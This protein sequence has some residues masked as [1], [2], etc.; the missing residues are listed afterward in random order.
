MDQALNLRPAADVDSTADREPTTPGSRIVGALRSLGL[1][2]L[3]ILGVTGVTLL[4]CLAY[5]VMR[6]VEPPYTLLYGGLELDDSAQ[7][8]SRLEAMRVPFRL[9]G[10]GS[11]ILVPGT[12]RCACA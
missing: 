7:I 1:T 9:Q 12:R 3:L 8:V 10:D 5:L 2:R 4:A 6:A 11:A